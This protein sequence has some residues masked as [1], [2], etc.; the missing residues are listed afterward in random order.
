MRAIGHSTSYV[1][2]YLFIT[3]K[4]EKAAVAYTAANGVGTFGSVS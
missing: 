4:Y 3:R 2:F 1:R